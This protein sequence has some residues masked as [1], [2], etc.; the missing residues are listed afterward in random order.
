MIKNKLIAT[1]TAL[2]LIGSHFTIASEPSQE[3]MQSPMDQLEGLD[4][5][6]NKALETF[7]IP[8]AA[9]GIIIDGKVVLTKGYGLRDQANGLPVTENTLFAI[10]SCTKAFT[11]HVLGQ[12]ADE[13]KISW[14]DPVIKY[15]PE[16]R[17]K[18]EYATHHITIRDLVT[19]QSGLP[20]HDLLWYNSDLSRDDLMHR[21]QHLEPSAD[22]RGKFQ[23]NNLM[24]VM[25][26]LIIEKVTGFTWEEAVQSRILTP[27]AMNRS[28]FSVLDSQKSDDFSLPHREKEGFVESVPFNNIKVAG[29]AG[30]INSSVADMVKWVGLQLSD[31]TFEGR[32]FLKKETLQTMHTAQVSLRVY[33]EGPSD[34]FAYGLGWMVGIHE[35]RYLV[36]HGGGI[37]GFISSTGFLPKEKIGV[38]VLTNSDSGMMFANSLA[39]AILDQTLGI[40]NDDWM[41]KVKENEEKIKRAFEMKKEPSNEDATVVAEM[42]RPFNDY[43]GEFEH[44]GYGTVRVYKDGDNLVLSYHTLSIPLSHRCFDHFVGKWQN[45]G[46]VTFNCSFVRDHFGEISEVNIPMESAVSGITFKRKAGSELLAADYLKQF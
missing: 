45:F 11:T 17:L 2:S 40:A 41:S 38:V 25:A 35:G 34:Y 5:M 9:V 4:A 36:E 21:L 29:P 22:L 7:R 15:L 24:Y 23:Y 43:V 44:P 42:A 46:A 14:D 20:R 3:T 1:L 32:Q 16:F 6:V 26:G 12:L 28:N 30:S 27:L 39:K 10:G 13:G 19:H 18:D 31:G 33:P 8:G 37:D